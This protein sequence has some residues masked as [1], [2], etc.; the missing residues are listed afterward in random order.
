MRNRVFLNVLL[1]LSKKWKALKKSC[2]NQWEEKL[3]KTVGDK[4]ASHRSRNGPVFQQNK[5]FI[6]YNFLNKI[7]VF[8]SCWKYF[9]CRGHTFLVKDVSF[10]VKIFL[11]AKLFPFKQNKFFQITGEITEKLH[12][13]KII[14]SLDIF[15]EKVGAQEKKKPTQNAKDFGLRQENALNKG[16]PLVPLS[17]ETSPFVHV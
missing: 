7:S 10:L 15:L 13:K 2:L 17:E 12:K 4:A 3:R 14:I 11:K 6:A 1:K 8:N 16:K 9:P 5:K